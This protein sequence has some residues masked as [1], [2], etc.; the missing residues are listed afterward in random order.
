MG[1]MHSRQRPVRAPTARLAVLE[2]VY[3]ADCGVVDVV[4]D[5]YGVSVVLAAMA[6]LM[7]PHDNVGGGGS[8]PPGAVNEGAGDIGDGDGDAGE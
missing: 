8:G 6:T 1:C 2:D 5:M 3:C 7:V 4:V